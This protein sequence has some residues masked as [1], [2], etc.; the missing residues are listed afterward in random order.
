MFST[1][2]D[3]EHLNLFAFLCSMG[4]SI[5]RGS[6]LSEKEQGAVAGTEQ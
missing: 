4:Y 1:S 2:D 5:G 3:K 6:V